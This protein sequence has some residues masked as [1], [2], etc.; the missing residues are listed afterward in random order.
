M[1]QEKKELI[2]GITVV[3]A[4]VLILLWMSIG[5]GGWLFK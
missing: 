5:L 3:I 1:D 2:I 4:C